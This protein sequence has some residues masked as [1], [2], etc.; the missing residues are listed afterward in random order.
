MRLTRTYDY[1]L[2]YDLAHDHGSK[3]FDRY[4]LGHDASR[5]IPWD[6]LQKIPKGNAVL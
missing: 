2:Y 4:E 1:V 3:V 6:W 5:V